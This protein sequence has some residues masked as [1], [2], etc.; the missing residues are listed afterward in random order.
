MEDMSPIRQ[1]QLA[2]LKTLKEAVSFF[3]DNDIVY[4]A[5]GGTLLG[6]VRH[7]GFIPWDDDIDL[8]LPRESYDRL[9]SLHREG[10]CPLNIIGPSNNDS[11]YWY[12]ARIESRD[13]KVRRTVHGEETVQN[14]WMDIFP[15]D[16]L[17]DSSLKKRIY[18]WKL[19]YRRLRFNISRLKKYE[20][21]ENKLMNLAKR[22]LMIFMNP[23][24]MDAHKEYVRYDRQMKKY[25][26]EG[27]PWFINAEGRCKMREIAP[28]AWLGRRF[29]LPFEDI[30]LRCIEDY[31]RYLTQIYGNYMKKPDDPSVY[32]HNI[33]EI[34]EQ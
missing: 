32:E 1:L 4:Y 8:G 30:E 27:M 5:I 28:A 20:P 18:W 7:N 23:E 24:K 33:L 26:F 25:G 21:G 31:D 13:L 16:G 15:L 6:A 34:I 11:C 12:P 17:P 19:S 22:F 3:D 2:E 9:I 29:M 10:K 14:V